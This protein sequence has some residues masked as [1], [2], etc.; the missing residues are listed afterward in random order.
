MGIKPATREE[1]E[2]VMKE[3]QEIADR[4]DK[5]VKDYM[6]MIDRRCRGEKWK[7]EVTDQELRREII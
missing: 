1:T 5:K 7:Q 6:E 2:R 3:T 4:V